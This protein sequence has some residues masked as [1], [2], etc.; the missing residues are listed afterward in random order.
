MTL[1]TYKWSVEEYHLMI[2]AGLL[3]GKSVEL[4]NGQIIEMSPERE[5]HTYANDDVA[6]LLREKLQGL[7]KIRESHPIT[8][9]NSEPEPDIA[10]VRLPKTIY[11]HHHPYSQDI[12]W[13]IEIS[14]ETLSQD[15]AEKSLIYARNYILEYW[16]VDLANNKLIVHTHPKN[17]SYSQIVE[18]ISGTISPLAF[19]DIKIALEQLLLF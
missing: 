13:L 12:Y 4:L 10:V 16:V 9:D 17:N 14:N 6:Q 11:S 3:E 19:P 5:E 7:A 8:L 15:L 2:K 1:T 18:Y